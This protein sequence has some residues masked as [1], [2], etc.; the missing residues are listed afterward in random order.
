MNAPS[1]EPPFTAEPAGAVG[2][3]ARHQHGALPGLRG[4]RRV[5]LLWAG[6]H[7][8]PNRR[9]GPVPSRPKISK[10]PD[11]PPVE[12]SPRQL[13]A[14]GR[15]H[16]DPNHGAVDA[17]D[18]AIHATIGCVLRQELGVALGWVRVALGWVR[19]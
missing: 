1:R 15:H 9:A 7:A 5:W 13:L 11:R 3:G 12:R 10:D 17:A 6:V 8:T 4:T 18:H 14:A 2:G 19:V 16:S